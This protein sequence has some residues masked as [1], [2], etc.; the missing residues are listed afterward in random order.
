MSNIPRSS[1]NWYMS[2]LCPLDRGS[3]GIKA[4]VQAWYIEIIFFIC[5]AFSNLNVNETLHFFN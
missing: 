1:Q 4:H 3:D 5:V 2:N